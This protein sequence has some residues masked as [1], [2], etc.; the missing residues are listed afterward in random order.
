MY[1]VILNEKR[2][3]NLLQKNRLLTGLQ[4]LDL[5]AVEISK[6]KIHI[7]KMQP[8]LEITKKEVEKTMQILSKDK[9]EPDAEKI[10]VAK[11]EAEATQQ[12]AE[13]EVL[14]Q[15]A[16]VELSKATPL[17][18]EAAKVLKELKKDDFYIISAIKK[19]TPAV[20]LGMEISCH[21]MGLKATKQKS[22]KL[23]AIPTATSISLVETFLTTQV[24]SCRRWLTLRRML[25]PNLQSSV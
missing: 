20:V 22:V 21:M 7:D 15:E 2:R 9:A 3:D 11:D 6:L 19:P 17:L 8:E 13:A 25:S 23:M 24:L 10:I 1:K 16:E 5:A 18:E 12:E 4:V 14:K